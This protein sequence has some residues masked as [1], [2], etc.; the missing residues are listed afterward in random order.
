MALPQN[1][2][3]S[4]GKIMDTVHFESRGVS[5]FYISSVLILKTENNLQM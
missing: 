3:Q 4:K 5:Y 2:E 1:T